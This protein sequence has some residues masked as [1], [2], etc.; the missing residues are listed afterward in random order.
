MKVVSTCAVPTRRLSRRLS[1]V[2]ETD[3]ERGTKNDDMFARSTSLD[4]PL[5]VGDRGM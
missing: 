1:Y 2:S 3:S 5:A 4:R